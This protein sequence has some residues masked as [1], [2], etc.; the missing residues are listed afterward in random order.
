MVLGDTNKLNDI[1]L[2]ME[3]FVEEE[4]KPCSVACLGPVENDSV[5]LTSRLLAPAVMMPEEDWPQRDGRCL[6]PIL[7]LR[8]DEIPF[9]PEE[10]RG[11]AWATFYLDVEKMATKEKLESGSWA[12]RTYPELRG[13]VRRE[14]PQP[15]EKSLKWTPR[16]IT[17]EKRVDVLDILCDV[18][19]SVLFQPRWHRVREQIPDSLFAWLPRGGGRRNHQ[20]TKLG[21]FPSSKQWN[22]G[23]SDPRH[24]V[25]Q[26]FYDHSKEREPFDL[27]DC[28]VS[29]VGRVDGDWVLDTQTS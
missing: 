27:C 23:P 3:R 2:E 7:N 8:F 20:M 29:Y 24:F 18:P 22:V 14:C 19:D 17:W 1:L 21:G 25:F 9:V 26:I 6:T 11:F 16:D 12:F 13:L 5:F 28:A 15:S 10:L 4:G